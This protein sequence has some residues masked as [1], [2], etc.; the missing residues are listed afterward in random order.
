MYIQFGAYQKWCRTTSARAQFYEKTLKMVDLIDDPDCPRSSKHR[1]L[2]QAEVKKG[3]KAVQR[4]ITAIENFINPFTIDNKERLYSLASGAPVPPEVEKDVLNAEAM[5]K[6]AKSH[7]V[8]RLESGDPNSFFDPIKRQ[9]LKTMESCNKKITLTSSE[10][11][12]MFMAWIS[13]Y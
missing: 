12:V 2:E 5:G 3:E 8:A 7:F 9:K 11:K 4:A 6:A 1:E 10:G 13:I